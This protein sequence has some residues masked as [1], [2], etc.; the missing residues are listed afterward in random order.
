MSPHVSGSTVKNGASPLFSTR[1]RYNSSTRCARRASS[2]NPAPASIKIVGN[3]EEYCASVWR[4]CN[5]PEKMRL[6]RARL[7][8]LDAVGR[9]G[10]RV[11]DEQM[12]CVLHRHVTQNSQ[13]SVG[14]QRKTYETSERTRR[15][16]A[17]RR[18]P[19]RSKTPCRGIWIQPE[20]RRH[21]R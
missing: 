21:L 4:I 20:Q 8:L 16:R 3:S 2:N 13:R 15:R 11:P 5:P 10:Q 19:R 18:Q 17:T 1:V 14:A 9:E 6:A 12:W 7:N